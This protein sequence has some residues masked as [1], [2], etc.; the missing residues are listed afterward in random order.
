M[1]TDDEQISNVYLVVTAPLVIFDGPT[2]HLHLFS[3]CPSPGHKF[4]R[5]QSFE[6]QTPDTFS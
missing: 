6:S 3:S 1:G 2:E 4:N 5:L